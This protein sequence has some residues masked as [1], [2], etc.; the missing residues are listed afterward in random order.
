[1]PLLSSIFRSSHAPKPREAFRMT[2]RRQDLASHSVGQDEQVVSIRG[3]VPVRVPGFAVDF[4]H[5]CKTFRPI[6]EHVTEHA[7]KHAW[8]SLEVEAL[9][10]WLPRL[11]DAGL[12]VSA[13]GVQQRCSQST[14]QSNLPTPISA[15][16]FPTGGDRVDLVDRSVRSFV[17]NA[18]THGRDV[19]FLVADSSAQ[20]AQREAFRA[21][22]RE[23]D[24]RV[25]YAGEEEKRSLAKGLV[26][27]G[28]DPSIVE[29]AL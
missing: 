17:L 10:S 8:G 9:R 2:W 12:L 29:F 22:L 16:G 1:M 6:E 23:I 18:Q 28:A 11:I 15:I 5:D 4:V 27:A 7:D 25:L 13:E 21:R 24:A 14:G 3:G 19:E 20:P 26:A